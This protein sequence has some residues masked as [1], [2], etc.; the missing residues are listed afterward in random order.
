VQDARFKIVAELH[1]VQTGGFADDGAYCPVHA[2]AATVVAPEA[3]Q[4]EALESYPVLV[5]N[6]H[7]TQAGV[8][9]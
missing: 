3:V 2:V 5:L 7:E 4:A 6:V 1:A 9:E 8:V